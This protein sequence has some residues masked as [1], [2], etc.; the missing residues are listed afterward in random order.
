MNQYNP[1]K[2][3]YNNYFQYYTEQYQDRFIA[4]LFKFKM[5]GY[6]LDIGCADPILQNNSYFFETHLNWHGICIDS[7]NQNYLNRKNT[8][9]YCCDATKINY[10]EILKNN[11]TPNIVDYLSIDTDDATNDV[12]KIIPFDEYTFSSITIEHDFYKEG[13]KRRLEQR[14]ILSDNGFHLL[15]SNVCLINTNLP[16]EDWWV[17]P[18]TF[19]LKDLKFLQSENETIDVV[20]NKFK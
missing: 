14:K 9:F 13:E 8:K 4:N 2:G 7:T 3:A 20:V 11:N 6:F 1:I 17:N 10:K 19:D 15:C 5:N 16:W 18:K 12:L